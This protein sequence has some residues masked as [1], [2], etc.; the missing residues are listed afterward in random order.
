MLLQSIEISKVC[1]NYRIRIF[2]LCFSSIFSGRHGDLSKIDNVQTA[3]NQKF[4]NDNQENKDLPPQPP[5]YRQQYV[6]DGSKFRKDNQARKVREKRP[7]NIGKSSAQKLTLDADQNSMNISKT[8]FL[9]PSTLSFSTNKVSFTPDHSSTSAKPVNQG[10][11]L[12][13]A[14]CNQENQKTLL[15]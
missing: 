3:S 9:S 10:S 13:R 15:N 12:V 1:F 4:E 8:T 2:Q 6:N 14:Y 7:L 5:D 11:I